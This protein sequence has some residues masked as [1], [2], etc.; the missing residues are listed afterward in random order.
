MNKAEKPNTLKGLS[1]LFLGGRVSSLEIGAWAGAGAGRANLRCFLLRNRRIRAR[2][3]FQGAIIAVSSGAGGDT[4]PLCL[5]YFLGAFFTRSR[6]PQ[7]PL[8]RDCSNGVEPGD[9]RDI[10]FEGPVSPIGLA[11]FF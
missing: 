11:Q 3:V 1:H 7:G 4:S 5:E 8:V 6:A 2:D 10:T 9:L